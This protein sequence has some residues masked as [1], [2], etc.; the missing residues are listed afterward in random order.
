MR[1]IYLANMRMPSERA[2]AVQV[3]HMCNA[4]AESGHAVHLIAASRKTPI[5]VDPENYYKTKFSF[6]FSKIYVPDI[7]SWGRIFFH[8]A[9]FIFALNALRVVKRLRCD[10]VYC[11]DESTLYLLSFFLPIR[12]LVYESHEARFTVPVR[13]ILQKGVRCVAISE[14]V[15]DFYLEQ[16]IPQK[17]LLVAH[18]AIDDSFFKEREPQN[19]ARERLGIDQQKPIAL[20]IGGFDS[21]KGAETFFEAAEY[22]KIATFV[23]IGG[24][25]DEIQKYTTAYPKVQFLGQRPYSEVRDNQQAADVLVVPNTQ[26]DERSA[27]YTSPLKLFTHLASRVPLI[28]SDIPSLR[29]VVSDTHVTFTA[30]DDA[31]Q[32]AE[33]I[34]QVL[35]D[36]EVAETKAAAAYEL[37]QQ[38]TWT[39]RA[40]R[41]LTFLRE[42]PAQ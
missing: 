22:S 21:W 27:K 11:R 10:I 4:F 23:A 32:L 29:R 31:C 25:T 26:H 37:S 38:H 16:G 34:D 20:Y 19:V 15:R 35:T 42:T 6:S 18:D 12:K 7:V 8:L 30:P 36:A 39:H 40:E 2:H 14:G 41:I 9:N 24:T 17:Q 3:V 13:R 28:V 1:L 5:A 33:R